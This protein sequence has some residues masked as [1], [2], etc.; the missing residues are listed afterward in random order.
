MDADIIDALNVPGLACLDQLKHT[1]DKLDAVIGKMD[2]MLSE[3]RQIQRNTMPRPTFES[4][5][6]RP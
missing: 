2:L 3:L 1:N 6:K 5:Y 4:S